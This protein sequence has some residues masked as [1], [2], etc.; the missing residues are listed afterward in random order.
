M[1]Q[2]VEII[3]L[4]F[5]YINVVEVNLVYPLGRAPHAGVRVIIKKEKSL[6]FSDL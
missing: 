5:E 6:I 3:V 4:S 2:F 1:Q